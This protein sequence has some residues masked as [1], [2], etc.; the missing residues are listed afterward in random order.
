MRIIYWVLV[1]AFVS[2]CSSATK[3]A[4]SQPIAAETEQ[5]GDADASSFEKAIVVMSIRAEYEWVRARYPDSKMKRQRLVFEKGT[6][7][8]V[9]TFAMPDGKDRDFYFDISKFYGKF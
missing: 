6:P 8:D 2:G 1:C 9:L 4:S 7:Y 5:R 3:T